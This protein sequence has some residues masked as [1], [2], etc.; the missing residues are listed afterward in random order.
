MSSREMM[1]EEIKE[2]G[3][4]YHT[5]ANSLYNHST[6][7]F[8]QHSPFICKVLQHFEIFY[9]CFLPTSTGG[10]GAAS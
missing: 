6:S 3:M 9:S 8:P 10:W 7:I 1:T 2:R 4:K 5:K